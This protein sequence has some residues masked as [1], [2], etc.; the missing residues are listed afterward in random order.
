MQLTHSAGYY[1]YIADHC[2]FKVI[3][4]MTDHEFN[5]ISLAPQLCKLLVLHVLRP[6]QLDRYPKLPII[7]WQ[8]YGIYSKYSSARLCLISAHACEFN[9]E[10]YGELQTPTYYVSIILYHTSS[11]YRSSDICTSYEC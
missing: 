7:C 8:L 9:S 4:V 2:I 6:L 3:L 10:I 5:H 11:V 1:C